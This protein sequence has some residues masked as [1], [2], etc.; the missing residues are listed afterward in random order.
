MEKPL[1]FLANVK[2]TGSIEVHVDEPTGRL[3]TSIEFDSPNE[4]RTVYSEGITEIG[5]THD[6]SFV[7]SDKDV[8]MQSWCFMESDE[9]TETLEG[10]VNAD[11][12][13]NIA[14]V[15][16][17]Q[18]WLLNVPNTQ[19]ANWRAAELMQEQQT[20]HIGLVLDEA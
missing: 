5:G 8:A 20:Q 12:K 19:L 17:L 10:D 1:A 3:L 13:F 6:L 18:K 7:Y 14:D 16:L 11:G 15:V 2:G 9:V 4:F